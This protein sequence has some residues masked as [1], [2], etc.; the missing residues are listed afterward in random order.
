M[1]I[2]TTDYASE[3]GRMRKGRASC[4]EAWKTILLDNG[5]RVA[6]AGNYYGGRLDEKGSSLPSGLSVFY[7]DSV[8]YFRRSRLSLSRKGVQTARC[9]EIADGSSRKELT[10]RKRTEGER[11]GL[12][13]LIEIRLLKARRRRKGFSSVGCTD[14]NRVCQDRVLDSGRRNTFGSSGQKFPFFG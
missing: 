4:V 2:L 9:S 14:K 8:E 11:N 3:R 6:L 12:T 13:A 1:E 7:E 10:K 5:Q